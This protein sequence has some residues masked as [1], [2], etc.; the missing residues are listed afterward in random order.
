MAAG[1]VLRNLQGR[2]LVVEPTCKSHWE[3]PG[4]VV[5]SGESPL[6]AVVR[7]VR[8]EIGI[9][10]DVKAF[11]L[12]ALDYVKETDD[13]T[14]AL[15]FV[16]A[17]PDLNDFQIAAIELPQNEL[18]GFAFLVPEQAAHLLG[19]IVGP[20][21]IRTVTAMASGRVAYWEED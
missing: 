4:G 8:E 12:V 21:L 3:L 18:K 13:R 15:Q 17:G 9:A 11:S 14:E 5:E 16:S 1:A 7:E 2:V 10:L 20:R 19:P 6:A